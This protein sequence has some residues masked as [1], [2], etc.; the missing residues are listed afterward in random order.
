MNC[1]EVKRKMIFYSDGE[2]SDAES[3]AFRAH[4]DDCN[5]CAH[6]YNELQS[7]ISLTGKRK[8]L[9]SNPFLFTRIE[10][11]L[12]AM[13]NRT[14][15]QVPVYRRVLQPVSLSLM[16]AAGLYLGILLGNAYNAAEN[17]NQLNGFTTEYYL[18]DFQQEDIE[19][20][21]LNE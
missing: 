15:R 8:R 5:E 9:E 20:W 3:R 11:K 7:T 21:L 2:L 6:L 18:N 4:L 1:Q 17:E 16:V 12:E 13:E 14:P 10:E 19:Y